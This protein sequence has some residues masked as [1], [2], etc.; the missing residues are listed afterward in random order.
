MK[1][2][3]PREIAILT[4]LCKVKYLWSSMLQERFFS[5]VS[6]VVCYRVMNRLVDL[7]LVEKRLISRSS[8]LKP[9]GALNI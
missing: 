7:K 1:I 3:Q 6:D 8:K 4:L 2:L 9:I 5:E